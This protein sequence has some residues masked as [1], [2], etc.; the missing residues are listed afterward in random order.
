MLVYR[1]AHPDYAVDLTGE[2]SFLFGGRWNYKGERMLYTATNASLALLET[3][4]HISNYPFQ[5]PLRLLTI[6]V[7]TDQIFIPKINDLP[8]NWK[9]YPSPWQAKEVGSQFL[10]EGR[11]A[12][13]RVPSVLMPKD[14]NLLIHPGH[15][16][17]KSLR[18]VENEEFSPEKR[19]V[20][21]L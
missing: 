4:A 16:S 7:V 2:G 11:F 20:P 15:S 8:A 10:K 1:I 3:L 14:H 5:I 13:L 21:V 12:G 9:E 19:I 18:I 6:E 17:I